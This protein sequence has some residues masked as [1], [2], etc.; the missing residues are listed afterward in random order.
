MGFSLNRAIPLLHFLV[1]GLLLYL[2]VVML[3]G[4][5]VLMEMQDATK[6]A[7][8]IFMHLSFPLLSFCPHVNFFYGFSSID[9]IV[10]YSFIGILV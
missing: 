7:L 1:V 3:L 2:E 6:S 9:I 8:P 4:V 10:H 5:F